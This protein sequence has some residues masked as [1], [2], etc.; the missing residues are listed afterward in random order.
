MIRTL[1]IPQ[2][3]SILLHLPD[4]FIGQKIEI[5]AFSLAESSV[6]GVESFS[7]ITSKNLET[8][9]AN[10]RVSLEDFKFD[11]NQANDC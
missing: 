9:F 10:N 5:L 6:D 3:N 2:Q 4:A 8:H 11:R 1:V 7:Q